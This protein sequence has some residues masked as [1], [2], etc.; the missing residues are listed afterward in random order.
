MKPLRYLLISALSALPFVPSLA[1]TATQPPGDWVAYGRDAGGMRHAPLTQINRQNVQQVRVAWTYRT[2][3]LARYAGTRAAE[4]AAF[5]ATPLMV[6]GTLYFS[7][8][9]D[10]VI[11][12]NATT[13]GE[14]WVF[15]PK[16]D[17]KKDYSEITSRGVSTWPG[18]DVS[19]Q[20]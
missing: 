14:K 13:G 20:T 1:Q 11:A 8:P 5:E 3:E 10:R 17:L 2:G 9:S 12:L 6:D 15:D 18:P 16:V 7:T 4:K 19:W